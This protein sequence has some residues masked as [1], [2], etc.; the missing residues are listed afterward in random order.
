VPKILPYGGHFSSQ[1]MSEEFISRAVVG[2][3][4]APRV[5]LFEQE[6]RKPLL[7]HYSL[8]TRGVQAQN[9][10]TPI[11]SSACVRLSSIPR[12]SGHNPFTG[13]R[14]QII[15]PLL[16]AQLRGRPKPES[17]ILP[18]RAEDPNG[19][20]LDISLLIVGGLSERLT[21]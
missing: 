6:K 1:C 4:P 12:N 18:E 17:T 5:F 8:T 13:T 10:R 7:R 19:R 15:S 14:I 21:C 16:R 11:E 3:Q 9:S 20:T 2:F